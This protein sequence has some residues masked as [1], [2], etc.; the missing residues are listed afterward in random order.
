MKFD[1]NFFNASNMYLKTRTSI[2]NVVR[3]VFLYKYGFESAH[4]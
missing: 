3:D 4:P 2:K 1:L